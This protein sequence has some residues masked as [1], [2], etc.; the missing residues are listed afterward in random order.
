VKVLDKLALQIPD[1]YNMADDFL[2]RN[3]CEGRGDKI[4]IRCHDQSLT[5]REV[6]ELSNR[7]GNAM[8][9]SGV[10]IENRVLMILYDTPNLVA[11]YYGAIKIGAVPATVNTILNTEDY[12]YYLEDS[13]A[14]LLLVEKDLLPIVEPILRGQRYLKKVIVMGEVPGYTSFDQWIKGQSTTLACEPTLKDDSAFWQYSSGSTG[15][16]KG[17]VHLQHDMIFCHYGFAKGVLDMKEEDVIF[18]ASKLFFGYG[19]GNGM[20]FPFREGATSVLLPERPT[21]DR[22]FAAIKRFRPT[23]F[24]AV[25][26]LY[27]ALLREA[28]K[29]N[30]DLSSIRLCVSAGE[31]LPPEIY[32]RWR[33]KF[34]IEILDGLGSTEA[35]HIFISNRPGDSKPGSSGKVVPG[36]EVKIIA[37]DGD[38]AE[39]GEIGELMMKGDSLSPYYWNKHEATKK[40]MLGEW[41]ATGDKYFID[42]EGY[43]WYCGR[44]D[45]MLK[46][47]GIWVS[48][49]EI[50]YSLLEHPAVAEVAVVGVKDGNDLIKPEAY[51]VLNDPGFAS[52]SLALELQLHVKKDL[53][54]YKYPRKV[55]FVNE[56]PKTASGKIQRFKLRVG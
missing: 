38:E 54:P 52:D 40:R 50:E 55:H 26:S 51:V 32:R 23:L 2:D 46:V 56:L 18:S 9:L 41:F 19:M 33:E 4:A 15:K 35:L 36:Y 11:S 13:R 53:A 49:V 6:G 28:E 29:Q 37:E 1:Q 8:L 10:E 34:G 31:S 16:P 47:G 5:Y 44:S 39:I 7:V 12:R 42:E 24:F 21:P 3:I 20:C 43:Y 25:P 45:D 30:Y 27:S 17:T 14:K 48:P 22:V